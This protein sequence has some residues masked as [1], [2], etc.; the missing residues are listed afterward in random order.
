MNSTES[1]SESLAYE[2]ES[3]SDDKEKGLVIDI[4]KKKWNMAATR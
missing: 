3:E 2:E 4:S 1:S